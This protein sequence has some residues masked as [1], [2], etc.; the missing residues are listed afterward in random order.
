MHMK[1]GYI[2]ATGLGLFYWIGCYLFLGIS[3]PAWWEL[4]VL[5]GLGAFT[6]RSIQLGVV[7]GWQTAKELPDDPINN[8]WLLAFDIVRVFFSRGLLAGTA[9]WLA[10]NVVS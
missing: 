8:M 4:C 1:G 7:A 2:G 5:G 9:L 10:S 3:H 6:T